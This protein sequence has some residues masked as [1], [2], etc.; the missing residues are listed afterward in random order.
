M[1]EFDSGDE[2]FDGMNADKLHASQP[3][4]SAA[5]RKHE[6]ESEVNNHGSQLKRQRNHGGDD[7]PI[8]IS[9]EE[10]AAS[11]SASM[12]VAQ[13]LLTE[14]FGYESFRHEQAGAI[15][16]ILAGA[17]TLTVFPTGAGKSLCYQVC[18]LRQP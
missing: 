2:L 8:V 15:R 5:K 13:K 14:T 1:S 3:P 11:S 6:Q 17:N 10:D 4:A 12:H 7:S 16:R 9:N 18:R